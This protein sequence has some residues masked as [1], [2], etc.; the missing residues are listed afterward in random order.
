MQHINPGE[1]QVTETRSTAQS[2]QTEHGFYRN[3]V[4]TALSA[5][6]GSDYTMQSLRSDNMSDLRT[7][8]SHFHS[9][10]NIS[11]TAHIY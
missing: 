9:V 5:R 3:S 1:Q 7:V 8:R 11:L 6:G 4:Y 2:S 10:L